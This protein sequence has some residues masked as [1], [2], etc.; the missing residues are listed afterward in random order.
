MEPHKEEQWLSHEKFGAR[1][2]LAVAPETLCPSSSTAT[3]LNWVINGGSP[4]SPD[5]GS[6]AEL[7]SKSE[8]PSKSRIL[9]IAAGIGVGLVSVAVGAG[10]LLWKM[11][12]ADGDTDQEEDQ[13]MMKAPGTGGRPILRKKFEE[14]AGVFF[15]T[16][17]R[18]GD[19]V[20]V[21]AFGRD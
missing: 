18:K 10:F 21:G 12:T 16:Q 6:A 11:G 14:N 17:R 15:R 7:D 5:A 13:K 2:N 20:A 3:R 19:D 1:A 9:G 4:A 8:T